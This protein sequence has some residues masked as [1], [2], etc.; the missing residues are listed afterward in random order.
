MALEVKIPS[1]GES[2]NE[3]IL[4]SWLKNDGEFVNKDEDLFEI[5][6]EKATLVV[7]AEAAGIL[8]IMVQ[9]EETIATGAVACT[10]DTSAAP[11]EAV[12]EV[13]PVVPVEAAPVTQESYAKGV[14]S[15]AAQ[16]IL[17]EKSISPASVSG[18]GKAG[19]ITKQDALQVQKAS[20]PTPSPAVSAPAPTAVV[21]A[22]GT[23]VI[24]REKLSRLRKMIASRLVAVKNETAMLTTFNEVDMIEI[25]NIRK[26][27]KEQFQ[28]AH[29]I[30]LGFM[31]FFAKAVTLAML[32]FPA[33]NSQ[34]DGEELVYHDYAD[35]GISVSAPKGLVVPVIRNAEQMSLADLEREIANLAGKARNSKLS[36]DEMTGGTFTITNGGVFGSLMSTPILNPPQSA[37]LG[38]HNIVERPVAVNGKVEIRPMMYVALS[39]DHRV[40]D[41]RESVGF[42][43]KVVHLLQDPIRLLLAV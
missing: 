41:G 9:E 5:E 27:Y 7:P 25:M 13:T 32:D 24:R 22:T 37:I 14:P 40:I 31:S 38:M 2:I 28:E 36:V 18:T 42:L 4:T 34:I 3:V 16:K 20:I 33:V 8:K 30:R 11:A 6:S 39:Y 23:R 43:K 19:R 26:K 35:L 12:T 1:P 15:I 21:A 17:A 10:I 29:D